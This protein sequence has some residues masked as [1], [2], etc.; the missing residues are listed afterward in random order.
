MAGTEDMWLI[1]QNR[2]PVI[3]NTFVTKAI[4]SDAGYC[5][6]ACTTYTGPPQTQ[7]LPAF[8]QCQKAPLHPHNSCGCQL[9]SWSIPWRKPKPR[10]I[11][12]I[13]IHINKWMCMR[14]QH[15][16]MAPWRRLHASCCLCPVLLIAPPQL[17]QSN[18]RIEHQNVFKRSPR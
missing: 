4:L 7:T 9:M 1:E 15:L 12:T 10:C 5:W 14:I 6:G 13:S 18:C 3:T 8:C 2:P 11:V 17:I 16:M